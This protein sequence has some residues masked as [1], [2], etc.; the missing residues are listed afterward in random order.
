MN[1][2]WNQ[3]DSTFMTLPQKS[4]VIWIS[5]DAFLIRFRLKIKSSKI[6]VDKYM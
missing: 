4:Q 5:F 1:D 6:K 2:Y 3:P